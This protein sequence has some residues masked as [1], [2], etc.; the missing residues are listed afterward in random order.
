[1]DPAVIEVL[2]ERGVPTEDLKP[3]TFNP[4]SVKSVD[5]I[6][7][8][9]EDTNIGDAAQTWDITKHTDDKA[10]IHAMC[11]AVEAHVR[12]LLIKF[13]I[14]PTPHDTVIPEFLAA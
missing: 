1:M 11:D 2:K 9:G 3:K 8:F 6:I 4:H 13:N 14:E 10:R 7:I 12:E 5:E